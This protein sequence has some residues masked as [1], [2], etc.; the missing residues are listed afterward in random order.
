MNV[1]HLLP[2]QD[3][4]FG[5]LLVAAALFFS[6]RM[7]QWLESRRTEYVRRGRRARLAVV[8]MAMGLLLWGLVAGPVPA[9]EIFAIPSNGSYDFYQ[10]ESAVQIP[11][12]RPAVTGPSAWP[13]LESPSMANKFSFVDSK[14]KDSALI[15]DPG[16]RTS[17]TNRIITV[18]G[19]IVW[20]PSFEKIDLG[21]SLDESGPVDIGK[22]NIER[23]TGIYEL[24]LLS[25]YESPSGGYN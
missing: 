19:R 11:D 6:L 20:F 12:P 24:A 7:K 9:K 17:L 18:A 1:Q 16:F 21:E 22:L 15:I 5:I 10:V 14:V 4:L 23:L 13:G 25:A 3:A 2:T 8:T